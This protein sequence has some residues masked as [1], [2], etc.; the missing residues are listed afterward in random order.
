VIDV[1][2]AT[3]FP[4]FSWSMTMLTRCDNCGRESMDLVK[5][6]TV[7]DNGVSSMMVCQV[8]LD[9]QDDPSL[10]DTQVIDVSK[11]LNVPV[12]TPVPEPTQPEPTEPVDMVAC[13]H[14]GHMRAHGHCHMCQVTTK[15]DY[16][17]CESCGEELVDDGYSTG[18]MCLDCC[19]RLLPTDHDIDL[20]LSDELVQDR[21]I[22]AIIA[23][24]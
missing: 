18:T 20:L 15:P 13:Q 5:V 24:M 21:I 1:I 19:L 10:V 2:T 11:Y 14:C 3:S 12:P 8:C 17:E 4:T 9:G 7:D 16:N 6:K 22:G 23:S